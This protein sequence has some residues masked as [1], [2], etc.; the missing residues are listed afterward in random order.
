MTWSKESS[1]RVNTSKK[2]AKMVDAD[3]QK[4]KKRMTPVIETQY[5]TD[6]G[7][8]AVIL[9]RSARRLQELCA[10]ASLTQEQRDDIDRLTRDCV[11]AATRI[12]VWA[13]AKS[14]QE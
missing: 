10:N 6:P 4:E 2:I 5:E 1:G 9:G 7:I 3:D 12:T 8:H 14:R 13:D 11:R